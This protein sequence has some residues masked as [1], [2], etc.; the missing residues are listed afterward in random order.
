MIVNRSYGRNVGH[1]RKSLSN[2]P[3]MKVGEKKRG[4]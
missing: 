3:F 1:G 4:I 2:S